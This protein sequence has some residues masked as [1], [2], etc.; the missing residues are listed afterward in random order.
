MKIISSKKSVKKFCAFLAGLFVTGFAFCQG[1]SDSADNL[2]RKED[3]TIVLTIDD[4]VTYSLKNSPS[5]KTAQIDL[6]LAKWK[7]NTAWNSF[8]PTVQVTGTIARAND[9][10]SSLRSTN[11]TING[12]KKLYEGLATAATAAGNSALGYGFSSAAANMNPVSATENMHWTAM[13]NLSVSLNFNVA[14]IQNMRATIAQYETGKIS[15]AQTVKENE[16]S[17]R[18]LFYGLLLQQESLNLQKESLENARQRMTQAQTNYRNGYVPEI[19]YLQAQVA[20]E[21]QVPVVEKAEM[22]MRQ[23]LD[24]F[25]FLIGLPANS[26]IQLNGE[27]NPKI[28]DLDVEEL[29]SKGL[30]QNLTIRTLQENIK[31]LKLQ[32]N[33]LDLSAYTPSLALSWNGNPMITSAFES[34]WGDSNNWKDQGAFS[35]TLAW[36]ITNMLPWSSSRVQARELQDNIKKLEVQLESAVRNT[37]LQIRTAVDTLAQCRHSLEN[38]QRNIDLAQR[39]YDM[40]SLAYRNGTTEYLD[41]M[42]AETQLNQ[43]KLSLVNEKF[44][45][46]TNLMDLENILNTTLVE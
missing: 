3:G 46:M 4:A 38:S 24:T 33:A 31:I 14:M 16:I 30:T 19:K 44:N 6:E 26:K 8:L 25:A 42:D 13:G 35:V 37:D 10:E 39:S 45:Y 43:A 23:Q 21:N 22:I 34:D 27:I 11:Q 17:V 9:V 2:Q 15:W 40:T 41:L 18:K 5:L 20:Y 32:S 28:M 7:K 29:I 36:N 1:I 12:N